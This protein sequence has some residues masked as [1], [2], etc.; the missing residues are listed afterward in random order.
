MGS[1]MGQQGSSCLAPTN[2]QLE[3][4]YHHWLGHASPE[5]LQELIKW[6]VIP[7]LTKQELTS[8]KWIQH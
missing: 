6:G 5:H 7:K 1:V 2:I 4:M 3:A 8:L